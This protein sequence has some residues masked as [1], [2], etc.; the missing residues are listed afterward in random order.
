MRLVYKTVN[1]G[2]LYIGLY[3]TFLSPLLFANFGS[4]CPA[5]QLS[6]LPS[7]TG[8]SPKEKTSDTGRINI[9]GL[10]PGTQYTYSVQPIF[11]SHNHGNAIVREVVTREYLNGADPAHHHS[12]PL[13]SI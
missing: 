12:A 1:M 4:L 8:E 13:T 10:I 9:P 2:L 7:Q 3:D 11:D 5:P 6:V